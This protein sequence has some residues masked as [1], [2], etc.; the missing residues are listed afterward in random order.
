MS[1]MAQIL[2]TEENFLLCFR[3]FLGSSSEFMAV[4]DHT[5]HDFIFFCI[6]HIDFTKSL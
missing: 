6:P 3:Q 4:R 1:Q 2:P 5:D